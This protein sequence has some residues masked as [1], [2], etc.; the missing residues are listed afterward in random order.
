MAQDDIG[1][2]T[3]LIRTIA[4]TLNQFRLYSISHPIVKD[5]LK[6][7]EQELV[8]LFQN[9]DR[10]V[11]GTMR[12][13]LV[14][15]GNILSKKDPAAQDLAKSLHRVGVEALTM[16]KGLTA[17][18]FSIFLRLVG[19]RPKDIEAK[20]GFKTA[21]EASGFEHL[22]LASGKFQL[23]EEGQNITHLQ[24]GSVESVPS[25]K[26]AD[27]KPEAVSTGADRKAIV[28]FSDIIHQIRTGQAGIPG[29]LGSV[30]LDCEKIVVQLEKKPEEIA[31]LAIE[32]AKDDPAH[33]ESVIRNIVRYLTE[34]LISFLIEHGKDITKALER[35]AREIENAVEKSVG[36]EAAGKVRGKV[37]KIF[38]ETIDDYRLQMVVKTHEQHRE[39][40]KPVQKIVQKL[41]QSETVR[42]RLLPVLREELTGKGFNAE[43]FD[44]IFKKMEARAAKKKSKVTVDAA[45][46][47]SLKTKADLYD[48]GGGGNGKAQEEIKKLKREKKTI[49]DEKERVDTVIRNL[50]EGLVVVDKS[51]KVV[52]MNPAAER[53]L[54]VKQSE[55]IGRRVTEDLKDE[56]LVAMT[57]G[58]ELRDGDANVSKNVEIVSLNDETKRVLQASTA[59]IENEDG[60]TIGMVSVLSDVTK[61]KE[62]EKLKTQFVANVSHELR[63]PLVAIQKSLALILGNEVGDINPEQQKFLSI[64][65]RNIERLSRLIN[66]LLDVNKLEAGRM[67]LRP[68]KVPVNELV[69]HVVSTMDSWFK[70]KKIQVETHFFHDKIEIEADPDRLTQVLTNLVGNAVKFTPD[71]GKI[72]VDVK[73]APLSPVRQGTNPS[74][75]VCQKGSGLGEGI[76]CIEIGVRDTGIGI[77]PEDQKKIFDKFVQV[78][79]AQPAGVSSTGLGLTIVKE[80]VELH[81]GWIA[82][83]SAEGK[84]SRFSIILPKKF[85]L[86]EE[87]ESRL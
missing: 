80:I 66:D 9:Q 6:K 50:A 48:Q 46:L 43:D 68:K 72:I 16:D 15:D 13:L 58:G 86:H 40:P 41:F 11:L 29:A 35:F 21:F 55:K 61:Q 39:D 67:T 17:L 60:Q 30:E 49:L 5:S 32:E 73:E 84:G 36:E 64:A 51:G 63:T 27:K 57:R 18:E 85:I 83:E 20:G 78:S 52:L 37:G 23:V 53:M 45:E 7:L 33:L 22:R 59:V 54:G 87:K 65:H 79:L 2:F 28:S 44:D 12:D 38:E 81:S 25:E 34:G 8:Q 4:L 74:N 69:Q 70:D 10:M 1:K 77:A 42:D 71:G 76:D 24:E 26:T 82:L 47:A 31:Q 75:D 3:P 19:M 56:H 14:V 62:V